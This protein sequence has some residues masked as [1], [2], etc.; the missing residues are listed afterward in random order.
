MLTIFNRNKQE[1]GGL[2]TQGSR[3]EVAD[4]SIKRRI[5]SDYELQFL[6]PMDSIKYPLIQEEGLIECLGQLYVIKKKERRRQGMG[7]LVN[8]TCPHVM[9]RLTDIRVPYE[10]AIEEK[11]G[12]EISYLTNILSAATN[13]KFTFQIMDSIELK[14]VYKWG[15]CNCLKALQDLVNLYE[16]EFVPDNYNIKIYKKINIDN[17]RE[18]RYARNIVSDDFE[19]NT[20]TLVT[21]MTGL[22]KDS[23]TIIGLPSS[24]LTTTERIPLEGIP[25]AIVNGIIKVP[26]IISRYAGSWATPDN[27]Y[28]DDE[29]EDTDIE[30]DTEAGK[31]QLLNFMR[32]RLKENEVPELQIKLSPV[33]LHKKAGSGEGAPQL[34]ETVYMVD[35][36]MQIDDISARIVEMTEYPFDLSKTAELTIANYLLRDGNQIL[37]DLE[38]SKDLLDNIFTKGSL[39]RS[40]LDAFLRQAVQDVLNSKTE[41]I[42]PEN[43][44]FLLQDRENSLEQVYMKAKGIIVSDDGGRTAKAAIT[45]KGV[46][47]EHI[48]GELGQFVQVKTDSI[49]V[50]SAPFA[51]HLISSAEAWSAKETPAG[52]QAKADAAKAAADAVAKAEA[53]L[54]ETTAKAYADGIVSEEEVRAIADAKSKLI[55]A[56]ADATAKA[57]AAQAAATK[58]ANDNDTELRNNLRITGQLPTSIALNQY[59]IT[60]YTTDPTQ[61]ARLD[62]RG[63]Y[64]KGGA[65]QIDGGLSDSQIAGASGWNNKTSR[66]DATGLYTSFIKA[67]QIDVATGKIKAAQI[68]AE[69][70]K[71]AA[72][73][74]T[75]QL[76]ASQIDVTGLFVGPG[77]IGMSPTAT[78]AWGQVT[79]KDLDYG[80]ITGSKPPVSADNTLATIGAQRLTYIGPTGI[81]TG[82]LTADKIVGGDF[83]ATNTINI[84]NVYTNNQV[85]QL[86]FNDAVIF[87]TYNNLVNIQANLDMHA[88]IIRFSC[89][90]IKFSEQTKV[91]FTGINVIGLSVPAR[92]Q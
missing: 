32:K 66:L 54:A 4:V 31:L 6:M 46:A 80:N 21:R 29:C 59:G 28:F 15:F 16:V 90:G 85:K 79:G 18:Y 69:Y 82:T 50:G 73:N 75:G 56:K 51:D 83:L 67:D 57:N 20:N 68:E 78:I 22:A 13:G 14:D 34:G 43:G 40:V 26:Y 77:G 42:Y 65:I 70:L 47:A 30:A 37:A 38:S 92:F 63:L 3:T 74:I 10:Y 9:R 52:A 12:C 53:E 84:G 19:T 87:K 72:A 44:G 35:P 49:V 1:V 39:N 76:K 48:I 61:Y 5:N 60:A 23:L 71:I 27:Y 17:G 55:E 88:D 62:Y 25:G 8:I 91:D 41:I 89:N 64:I 45:G 24:H 11:L 36:G 2:W 81:Y 58:V 33:D 86:G 7:K